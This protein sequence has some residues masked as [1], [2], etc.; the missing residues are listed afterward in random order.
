M[1]IISKILRIFVKHALVRQMFTSLN[2]ARNTLKRSKKLK[3]EAKGKQLTSHLKNQKREDAN[4]GY[5]KVRKV[6]KKI[7]KVASIKTVV[8][9]CKALS[10]THT[11]IIY[12]LGLNNDDEVI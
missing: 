8:Q 9:M 5:K 2:F 12:I 4:L 3:K 6:E 7:L 10:Q 11:D 1:Q